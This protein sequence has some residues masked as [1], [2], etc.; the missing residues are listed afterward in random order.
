MLNF[1]HLRLQQ[2]GLILVGVPIGLMLV[3]LIS[4]FV[5]FSQLENQAA[6]SERSKKIMARAHSLVEDYQKAANQLMIYKYTKVDKVRQRFEEKL[7]KTES[8]FAELQELLKNEPEQLQ[9]LSDLK[10][11]A[12]KGMNLM[13]QFASKL[14]T[15]GDIHNLEATVLYQ[16]LMA[17]GAHFSEKLEELVNREAQ[18][19]EATIAEEV[20]GRTLVKLFLLTG[21]F[22]A[23][24][25]G[26][27]LIHL[28]TK[29][30]T[31][32]L[33]SVVEN[34]VLLSKKEPLNPTLKGED[35]IAILDRFFHV[36]ANELAE[37]TRKEKLILDNAV[38]VICSLNPQGV[39]AA[40]NPAAYQSWGYAPDDLIGKSYTELI[41]SENIQDFRET[42][43]KIKAESGTLANVETR[44]ITAQ[45]ERLD[46]QWSLRWSD[47]ENLYFCVAHDVSDRKRVEQLK[48][49]FVAM[50]SHEL[51]TP[52]TALQAMLALLAT[53]AY[54]QINE[55]GEKR[56]K[57]A[58]TGVNRLILLITDLLDMEKMEA[59]KLS[60]TYSDID[61]AEVVERSVDTVEGFAQ[62]H[63]VSIK[64]AS[65]PITVLGDSDRLIQVFVNLL[66]NAV[67]YS[68][69]DG[70]VELSIEEDGEECEVHVVDHG[71]GIPQGFE[72]KIFQ[73][74][75]Q[76]PA[77][78]GKRRKGT[79]LGLPICKAIVEQH[80]GT[81]GVRQTPGGGS[82][83][84]FR[85]PKVTSP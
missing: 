29:N 31:S 27:G 67:K 45:S 46:V 59:G 54:G 33:G 19:N 35:E 43:E 73:R 26:M 47:S 13:R 61:L 5:V 7:A 40:V 81:I 62:E 74:Y 53:G 65:K 56:L 83:F 10:K 12:D 72:E 4:L 75:E 2:Q 25:V 82:T 70:T 42:L 85:I 78:D 77:Q 36:M 48:Q 51:R 32:R 52:L 34:T 64:V 16:G 76:A 68:E 20:R 15:E 41:S 9:L 55:S 84:W 24:A 18:R 30:T 60:M 11:S 6:D 57:S 63:D 58:K 8:S 3:V 39:F 69:E 44:I 17:A 49:D 79:G 14:K 71:P 38:D 66:S 80:G 37:A 1:S 50:I 22:L 28:F 21:V 23:I